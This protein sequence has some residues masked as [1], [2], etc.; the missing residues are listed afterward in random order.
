MVGISTVCLFSIL[1]QKLTARH[2]Y[3]GWHMHGLFVRMSTKYSNKRIDNEAPFLLP[4]SMFRSSPASTSVRSSTQHSHFSS[5]RLLRLGLCAHRVRTKLPISLR[6]C[7][8]LRM[9]PNPFR[10]RISAKC[11]YNPFGIRS[12]K[13]RHLKSFRIRISEKRGRGVPAA[14]AKRAIPCTIRV[15]NPT[16]KEGARCDE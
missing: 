16:S 15:L 2:E 3:S 10:I 14:C 8:Q 11:A 6:C 1:R 5:P 7:V 9:S 12:F 13:T 4:C